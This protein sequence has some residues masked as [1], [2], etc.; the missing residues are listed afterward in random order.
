MGVR[1]LV[2]VLF[3]LFL[4]NCGGGDAKAPPDARP[5]DA[6]DLL[7]ADLQPPDTPGDEGTRPD[8]AVVLAGAA[9]TLITPDFE[10]Y[11]D[12]NDNGHWDD[13]EPFEDLNDNGQLDTLEL[14]GFGWRH[15]TGVH[16]DL[17][18]R[19]AAFRIH[20]QWVVLI[21][22]DALGLGRARVVGI[23]DKLLA[24]LGDPDLLTTEQ[25]IVAATHSH[26]VPDSIGIFG[27]E[28]VDKDYLAWVEEKAAE[29]GALAVETAVEAE[30]LVTHA[31]VPE[32]V[33]DID[34]P[35]IKDPSVGIIH[36]R[37]PGGGAIATL[38]SVANHPECTWSKNTEVSA[39]FPYY[40]LRDVE[41]AA[42]GMGIYFSGA[43]GLMQSPEKIGDEGFDRAEKIGTAY[44]EKVL[45]A[46]TS[47]ETATPETLTPAF[48]YVTVRTALENLELYVGLADG[49]V[50]GYED[51]IY[52]TGEPPC[53]F[54]GC[55]D[56]PF[57]VWKLGS[58][59]TL[60]ALPGEFTPELIVGGI[61][62]PPGYGGPYPDAPP[63]PVL[64]DH[65]ATTERFVIGLAGMEAGYVY[66]KMTH[67]PKE[68]F[69][70]SHAPGPNVA[71]DL[72]TGL[73][74]L[75]DEVNG[76]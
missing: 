57:A 25:I 26:A 68:H 3:S 19:A 46:I 16:D 61:T 20:G 32:L 53:D 70:Q 71:M 24:R 22:V 75:V 56:M 38:V 36:A 66:P 18:C 40:L 6:P 52:L 11:T 29:A 54:F 67:E 49:V 28:G 4:L 42:G 12:Q 60:V 39:D 17:W 14:G 55:M 43:L 21:A 51:Y 35:D 9:K 37:K 48:G 62:T 45:A 50:D 8:D 64:A 72:M 69:S 15:P 59:L 41:A 23:Q 44:A 27:E 1:K 76:L 63:E 34:E 31:D 13:G 2:P 30:L 7:P 58:L 5:A 74:Q 10:P 73:V 65:L 33:R 47:A